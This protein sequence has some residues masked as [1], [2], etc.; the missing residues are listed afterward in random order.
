MI[1]L[2]EPLFAGN[3]KKYVK[4]CLDQGW[5]S[6]AGKYVDIFEKKIAKYTGAKY[7]IA[8][9]NGTS[10]LQVSLKL[11]GVKKGDE[12]IVPS[13]TFIA[14]VNAINYNNAK[15]V[16]M[17]CDKFCNIDVGK[18]INFLK[19]QTITKT[20]NGKDFTINKISKRKVAAIISTDIMCIPH[21]CKKIKT[22]LLYKRKETFSF[23]NLSNIKG[24]INY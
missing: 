5:V 21:G 2:H 14:P 22:L 18:T 11:V 13:M 20:K 7:G 8:C 12:V 19:S 16:F 3:E 1:S 24:I 4:N 9:I 10:A 6:S 17:D 15:P 23:D